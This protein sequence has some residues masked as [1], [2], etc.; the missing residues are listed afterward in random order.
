MA[1]EINAMQIAKWYR[2]GHWSADMVDEAMEKGYIT[3]EEATK[4]KKLPAKG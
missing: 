1:K 4:I 3:E 2:A